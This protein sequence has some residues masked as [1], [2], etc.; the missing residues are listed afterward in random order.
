[1]INLTRR[2]FLLGVA[3]SGLLTLLPPVLAVAEVKKLVVEKPELITGFIRGVS[4]GELIRE[5]IPGPH[6][7]SLNNFTLTAE[8][9]AIDV[10]P[11]NSEYRH[12]AISY[13]DWTVEAWIRATGMN[14]IGRSM[15]LSFKAGPN[16]FYRGDFYIIEHTFEFDGQSGEER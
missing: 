5:T 6:D 9:D 11:I 12:T 10:T 3:S 8:A 13:I 14:Y 7:I 1:M 2:N 15:Q 16:T 4:A